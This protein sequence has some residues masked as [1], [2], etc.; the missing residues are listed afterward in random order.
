MTTPKETRM[1][2]ERHV[3]I[4]IEL[5]RSIGLKPDE[6]LS[7]YEKDGELRIVSCLQ[8]IRKAQAVIAKYKQAGETVV[9]DFI[10]A[11]REEAARE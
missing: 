4:P 6:P 5:R 2:K 9:D 1:S 3:L 7:A 11:K 10:R 8:G